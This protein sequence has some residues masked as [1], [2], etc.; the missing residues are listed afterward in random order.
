M[1]SYR[2]RFEKLSNQVVMEFE[3]W[4][5]GARN[6]NQI[7]D[8]TEDIQ[9]LLRTWAGNGQPNRDEEMPG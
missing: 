4:K 8:R 3:R 2:E 7:I 1:P 9:A 6:H 5:F